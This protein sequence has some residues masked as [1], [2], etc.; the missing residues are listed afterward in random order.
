[1]M[2]SVRD[3]PSVVDLVVRARGGDKAAW[4]GIVER[5][6]A[7]VWSV[8]RRHGLVGADADDVGGSVWLRLVENLGTIRE[9][10]ALPGWLARTTQRECLQLLRAKKRSVPVDDPD[11]ADAAAPA[12]DEWVLVEERRNALRLAFA[13]LQERCQRLLSMLFDDP[14]KSYA[15]ISAALSM[16]IGAIGPNRERCLERLRRSG[17]LAGLRHAATVDVE[18]R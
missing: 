14:P 12:S 10:A 4:D 18:K 16:P 6:A 8:C 11:R 1:M 2:R 9:P 13:G 17:A 7:L 3:D 5:Y 15:E